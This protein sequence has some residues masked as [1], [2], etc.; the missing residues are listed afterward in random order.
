MMIGIS[1]TRTQEQI[2]KKMINEERTII[3]L[4]LAI[5]KEQFRNYIKGT[6]DFDEGYAKVVDT[7]PYELDMSAVCWCTEQS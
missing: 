2:S 3:D 4:E 5:K 7:K 1:K 6:P